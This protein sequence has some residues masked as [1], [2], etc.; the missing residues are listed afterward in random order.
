MIIDNHH[1]RRASPCKIFEASSAERGVEAD[2]NRS[3]EA[4]AEGAAGEV[5]TST[6]TPAEALDKRPQDARYRPE[7]PPARRDSRA[8]LGVLER[9]VLD[10][11]PRAK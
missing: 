5:G 3:V 11:E 9:L 10:V 6:A 7:I 4:N 2:K 1:P 8:D